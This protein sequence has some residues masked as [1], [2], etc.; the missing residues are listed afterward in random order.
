MRLL[1]M[2]MMVGC[3]AA[4][5]AARGG[6]SLSDPNIA[7]PKRSIP[8]FSIQASDD[9]GPDGTRRQKRGIVAGFD[10]APQTTIG[11]GLFNMV[12]RVRGPGFESRI[13]SFSKR[14]RK[15]AVGMSLR[16]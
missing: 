9:F 15:A 4:P 2:A 13:D 1:A 3:V 7:T 14:S 16:F 12:P 10:V 5:A 6:L 8:S 11:V